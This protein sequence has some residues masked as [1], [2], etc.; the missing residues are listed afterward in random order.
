MDNLNFR[1]DIEKL[2]PK[3]QAILL[4][5]TME[6]LRGHWGKSEG[7]INIIKTICKYTSCLP[8]DVL[9]G[10]AVNAKSFNGDYNDGRIFRDDYPTYYTVNSL[11]GMKEDHPIISKHVSSYGD[12]MKKVYNIIL[13]AGGDLSFDDME[14]D[15]NGSEK[16]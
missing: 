11:I 6:S 13:K 14:R 3:E 9:S 8:E 16:D 5:M 7:R 10:I 4:S 12:C 2:S 1:E 15:L